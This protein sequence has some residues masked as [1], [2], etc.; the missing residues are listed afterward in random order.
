MQIR[1]GQGQLTELGRA[2]Q[3]GTTRLENEFL[4]RLFLAKVTAIR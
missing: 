1:K 2:F 3:T 4:S